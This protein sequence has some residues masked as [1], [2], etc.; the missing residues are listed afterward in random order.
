MKMSR[1]RLRRP[2][3][4]TIVAYLALFVALGGTA[5]ATTQGFVLGGT[6]RV[7]AAS[8]VT[9]LKA[10]NTQNKI[11]SPLLTL[12]N[13]TPNAGA[14]ALALNVGLG[15]APFTTNSATKVTKLNADRLDGLDST[16]FLRSNGKAVDA[17]HADS[18]D[19]A[20]N[21][22]TVDGKGSGDFVG[23]TQSAGG[24]LSGPFSNLTVGANSVTATNVVDGSLRDTDIHGVQLDTLA[25]LDPDLTDNNPHTTTRQIGPFTLTLSCLG[26]S[27]TSATTG[28][29]TIS[30]TGDSPNATW[31]MDSHASNGATDQTGLAVNA[32]K[33][34]VVVGPTTVPHIVEGDFGAM[35]AAVVDAISGNVAVRV[36]HFGDVGSCQFQSAIFGSGG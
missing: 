32:V 30:D 11:V 25:L 17:A 9:N 21:A 34:L 29:I 13:L 16:A 36:N 26:K 22:N 10:D 33:N 24:D 7:N 28:S 4:P 20:G 3:H 12:K 6:N 1:F 5:V 27:S 31:D 18:A 23:A 14:T 19:S 35:P 8:N 2:S 15:H